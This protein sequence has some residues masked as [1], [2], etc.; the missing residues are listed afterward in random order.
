M[1]PTADPGQKHSLTTTPPPAARRWTAAR[2]EM[3]AE[4]ALFEAEIQ[5]LS[6]A[7]PAAAAASTSAA[8]AAPVAAAPAAA[9][10]A[11][12]STTSAARRTVPLGVR[13]PPLPIDGTAARWALPPPL[14]CAP[15]DARTHSA[16]TRGHATHR[17]RL[18][19]R[20]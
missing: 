4:L 10:P 19:P 8:P 3:D 20:P 5:K 14:L 7:A 12:A 13:Q 9:A 1:D 6:A 11:A 2:F 16:A 15:A 18:G 17:P